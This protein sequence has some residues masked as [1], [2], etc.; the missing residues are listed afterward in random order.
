MFCFECHW[1]GA[2]RG[3]PQRGVFAAQL[4][5][6]RGTRHEKQYTLNRFHD[7]FLKFT[8]SSPFIGPSSVSD[9]RL[10]SFRSNKPLRPLK[11]PVQIVF[12]YLFN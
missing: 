3:E 10:L 7:L 4:F 6:T 5:S 1:L 2:G 12:D 11:S 8:G 9:M